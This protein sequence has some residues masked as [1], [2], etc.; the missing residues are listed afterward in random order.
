MQTAQLRVCIEGTGGWEGWR[1]ETLGNEDGE[2]KGEG[3]RRGWEVR[4]VGALEQ[5]VRG[6]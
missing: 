6:G 5:L 3:R 2:V 1:G 4:G